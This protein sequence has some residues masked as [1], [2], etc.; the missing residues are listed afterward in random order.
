MTEADDKVARMVAQMYREETLFESNPFDH[1]LH[2]AVCETMKAE[3]AEANDGAYGC[4]TGCEYYD[5]RALIKCD[6]P[7][8]ADEVWSYGSFGDTGWLIEKLVELDNGER[9]NLDHWQSFV[10]KDATNPEL[11]RN[12]KRIEALKAVGWV[13]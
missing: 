11:R 8:I 4:D 6:C 3:A 1:Q 10:F 13:S 7:T 9:D 12:L 2:L 5:L